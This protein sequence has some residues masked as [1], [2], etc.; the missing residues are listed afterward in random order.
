MLCVCVCVYGGWWWWLRTG[1]GA[2]LL[3][4]SSWRRSVV[5]AMGVGS[6]VGGG[7][8]GLFRRTTK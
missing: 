4:E 1:N 2:S 7:V 6:T 8:G 5:V 3:F